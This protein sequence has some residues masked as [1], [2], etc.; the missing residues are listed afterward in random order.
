MTDLL[1]LTGKTAFVTGASAGLGAHFAETLAGAG[2]TVIIAARREA[3]LAEVAARIRATGATCETVALDVTST[4]SIAAVEPL[5]ARVDI[6]VNNAGVTV[7]KPFLDQ[8]EEDWDR[9]LGTNAKGMFL[10]TQSAAR[11]MKARGTGGSI[12]NIASILGLR[13]GGHVAAYATSKAAAIQ[14]TK[15]SALELARFGI[16]V[17]CLCPG[18]IATDLNRDFWETELG[19]VMLKRIPQRR[20]GAARELDG[21]LLLLASDASSY[22]TG[23]VIVADGGHLTSTL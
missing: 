21:P 8:S 15:V 14:L 18:Y 1:S 19:K 9:V 2:A 17:N 3:A 6:L 7:D 22:M 23:S 12:I 13:Q 4:A 16:R 11:A 10:L 20:L 5:L